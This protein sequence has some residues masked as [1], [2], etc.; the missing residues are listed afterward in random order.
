MEPNQIRAVWG[1]FDDLIASDISPDAKAIISA[2]K[3]Q[4]EIMSGKLG[5]IERSTGELARTSAQQNMR[6]GFK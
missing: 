6:T 3:M 4:T 1:K 5:A 2:I